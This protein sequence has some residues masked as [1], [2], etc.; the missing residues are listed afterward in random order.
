MARLL[1]KA[2]NLTRPIVVG[3]SMTNYSLERILGREGIQLV[4]VDVGDR[5]VFQ[6]MSSNG[7]ALGGE[8]SGHIIFS[9]YRLSGDGLLTTL[10]LLEAMVAEQS[11]IDALTEDW[12]AA[13]QLLRNIPVT[14]TIPLDNL[15]GV[16]QKIDEIARALEGRGRIVVRYSGSEPLLRVMIESDSAETNDTYAEELI[17]VVRT[18][19]ASPD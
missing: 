18:A 11:S 4:R 19:L 5:Y 8:P 6:E 3:T 7:A 13:P 14:E 1:K 16:R 15:T 17:H 12:Q 9:D 2:D 10:K